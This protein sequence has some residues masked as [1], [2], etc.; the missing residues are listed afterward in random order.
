MSLSHTLISLLVTITLGNTVHAQYAPI[1]PQAR[2]LLSRMVERYRHLGWITETVERQAP[3]S[4]DGIRHLT[5][6]H[7]DVFGTL[8]TA[9]NQTGTTT[10]ARTFPQGH[11]YILY[12]TRSDR[13]GEY[14]K[15][16]SDN[17]DDALGQALG[18]SGAVGSGTVILLHDNSIASL[19]LN[20]GLTSLSMGAPDKIGDIP[21][22][23]VIFEIN[24]AQGKGSL[25]F[26]IG[27]DVPLL[28]RFVVTHADSKSAPITVTETYKNIQIGDS[29][30]DKKIS[31]SMFRWSPP[32]GSK[33]VA[34]F[35]QKTKTSK[36]K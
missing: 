20:R 4:V 1:D 19:L 30:F 7:S 11:S 15:Q 17:P 35:A 27:K 3:A 14:V 2:D 26:S 32:K 12:I 23:T 24:N 21:V 36:H 18:A 16:I 31:P 5:V 6:I 8:L 34:Y 28:Y 13:P 33:Q 25:T 22:Q 10:T 9:R 29:P